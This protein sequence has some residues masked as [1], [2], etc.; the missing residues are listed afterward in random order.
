MPETSGAR[1]TATSIRSTST[2]LAVAVANG[3]RA[4]RLLDGGALLAELERDSLLAERLRK[5]LGRVVVL[6]RDQAVEHLDHRHLAAE[7]A[8]D[9]GELAA[10]D[11]AAENGDPRRHLRLREQAGRVDAQLGV[12]ARDRRP[13]R[14]R[15]G[16][17]DRRGRTRTSSPPSTAIVF[18]SRNVPLP[19]THWTPLALK[20]EATPP[21]ICETTAA[22]HSFAARSRAEA[23]PPT[24][25]ACAN[26]S[27]AWCRKCAV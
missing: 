9:R 22:F 19:L 16:R 12:E 1:P 4:A 3:Q 24:R 8:E 11:P 27:R 5:L 20:S 18:A 2:R 6:L 15:A 26:E 14:E 23:R 17:D 10:D 13:D 7:G 21:V 25:R